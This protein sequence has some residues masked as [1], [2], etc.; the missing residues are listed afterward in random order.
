MSPLFVSRPNFLTTQ[1][2]IF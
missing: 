2:I 1:A